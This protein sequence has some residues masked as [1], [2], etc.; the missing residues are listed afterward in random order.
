MKSITTLFFCLLSTFVLSQE[1]SEEHFLKAINQNEAMLSSKQ[2]EKLAHISGNRLFK[3][4]QLVGVGNLATIQKQGILPIEIPG[5]KGVLVAYASRVETL[6]EKEYLWYGEL[7]DGEQ[8]SVMI[9]AKDNAIYGQINLGDEI[10]V[11]KDL[12]NNKNVLIQHDESLYGPDECAT[13]DNKEVIEDTGTKKIATR[14]LVCK[15]TARVLVLYTNNAET[16]DN[17]QNAAN[18]F[19]QQTNQAAL[20]S[21]ITEQEL[22]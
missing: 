18:L 22:G 13:P 7:R 5:R 1:G 16:T 4:V 12:G 15:T 19:V 8:G 20:N 9:I 6:S 17:P 21:D 2:Q 10:Y 3:K 14:S 11:L